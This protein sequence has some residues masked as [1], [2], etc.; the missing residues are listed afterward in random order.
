[1]K[2]TGPSVAI[3]G[4]GIG[5]LTA[6]LSLLRAG[7]DVQV[8]EQAEILAEVGAGIQVSPNA[9]RILQRLLAPNVLDQSGVRPLALHQRRWDDGRTLQRLPLG[10]SVEAAFAAPYY[11]FHRADLLAALIDALPGDRVHLGHRFVSLANDDDGATVGFA[12]GRQIKVDMLVGADGIQSAVRRTL[13]GPQQPR[14]TGC[15]AYRGLVPAERL[16]H[17]DLEVNS[18]IWLG[19]GRHFV[20]YFVSAGRLVNF[21][22]V[23]ERQTWTSESWTDRGQIAD[24]LDAFADWHRQVRDI[25][26][27]ADETFIWALH[28]RA[29]LPRWS[30][31]RVTL[32]GDSCHAMLPFM[33][34]GAAQAIE[35][36]AA[37]AACIREMGARSVAETLRRYEALRRP[38]TTRLQR[39]SFANKARFHLPDGARQRERDAGLDRRHSAPTDAFAWLFGYDA[40]VLAGEELSRCPRPANTEA[41]L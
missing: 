15:L 36:A 41:G 6:A 21:V 34:Q 27:A 40:E 19:P 20:H 17:L 24:A 30:E 8:F 18:T 29:A 4:G 33:A 26:S 10:S 14:F 13:F 28:D 16:A 38:R 5:G 39:I 9:S 11:N 31:G 25:I 22:A 37:L 23:V 7:C 32:L 3:I 12:N 1:M 35:D 2:F